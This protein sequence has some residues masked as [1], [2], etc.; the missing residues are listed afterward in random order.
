MWQPSNDFDLRNSEKFQILFKSAYF[1]Y[2][3]FNA[4]DALLTH[5]ARCSRS[6]TANLFAS[7][8]T[9]DPFHKYL[10]YSLTTASS[11]LELS[12]WR[13]DYDVAHKP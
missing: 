8:F 2:R 5:L 10:H 1:L 4:F 3:I 7:F 12:G 11:E 6:K 13:Y 9:E